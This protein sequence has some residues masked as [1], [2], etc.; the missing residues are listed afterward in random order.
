[1]ARQTLQETFVQFDFYRCDK[2]FRLITNPEL[3]RA[4]GVT[5]TG[6]PCPCGALKLR[7]TNM[8]WWEWVYPR[9]WSFAATRIRE[10][11]AAGLWRN[12]KADIARW[13]GEEEAYV[14]PPPGVSEL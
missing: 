3:H 12:L 6:K 9:V 5:G 2:C 4:L 7:P 8:H 10:L 11:G 1:M 13:N 14:A